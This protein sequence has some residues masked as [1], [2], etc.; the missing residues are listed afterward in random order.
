MNWKISPLLNFE[1]LGVFLNTLTANEKYPVRD[2][3]NLK[4]PIQL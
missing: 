4:F 1:M 2:Y 3:E